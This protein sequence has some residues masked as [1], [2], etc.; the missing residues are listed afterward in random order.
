MSQNTK[1][2]P[3][4]F[5]VDDGYIPYLAVTLQSMLKN[6]SKLYNYEIRILYTNISEE[7]KQK[8]L[9][10]ESKKVSIE[11]VDLTVYLDEIQDK[12][13]TRDYYTNTTYY[14]LFI[15]NL[16][17]QFDKVLYLDCDIVVLGDI[18]KLFNIDIED[19][20]IGACTCEAMGLFRDFTEYAEKVVGMR[21][22]KDY[23][24]AGILLM[25]LAEMRKMD[26][27]TKFI[28]L[29]ENIKFKVAQDQDYINRMCKG[30]IKYQE[31]KKT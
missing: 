26:L 27:Q 1:T 13:Y 24:N 11:F 20:L 3:I 18:S 12:F 15:P 30:R 29:L 25:N 6:A 8:I 5:A 31:K 10:Y 19:N 7:N 17:P 4:F 28:Y 16:Y 21:R 23:I 14:R 22:C 9:K 2:I